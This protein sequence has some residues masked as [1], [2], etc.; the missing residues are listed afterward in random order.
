[1]VRAKWAHASL[2]THEPTCAARFQW[3]SSQTGRC[4][5]YFTTDTATRF[6]S[7]YRGHNP[8]WRTTSDVFCYQFA[9]PAWPDKCNS[10]S[11]RSRRRRSVDQ[12]GRWRRSVR[13]WRRRIRW[14]RRSVGRGRRRVRRRRRRVGRGRRSEQR[15]RRRV[16][17]GHRKEHMVRESGLVGA[18]TAHVH[19]ATLTAGDR[20]SVRQRHRRVATV[21]ADDQRVGGGSILEA[22]RQ[23]CTLFVSGVESIPENGPVSCCISNPGRES[24]TIGPGG[25]ISTRNIGRAGDLTD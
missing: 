22:A 2:K 18:R 8:L 15:R 5:E 13:R 24:R 3:R 4:R 11:G 10:H 16:L 6:G 21:P 9:I 19:P 12:D 20:R 17:R 14:R 25:R 1:M 23:Q 7:R